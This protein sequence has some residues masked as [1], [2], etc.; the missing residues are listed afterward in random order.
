MFRDRSGNNNT[1]YFVS[2]QNEMT[3]P[4]TSLLPATSNVSEP[5]IPS[6]SANNLLMWLPVSG[7]S[8]VSDGDT[9]SHIPDQSG[10]KFGVYSTGTWVYGLTSASF[11]SQPALKLSSATG[12]WVNIDTDDGE[13]E[14]L[15]TSNGK[16]TTCFMINSP[17]ST[18]DSST[19]TVM[20]GGN[21]GTADTKNICQLFGGRN[22]STFNHR[23]F[24][25]NSNYIRGILTNN[26]K[27]PPQ[28]YS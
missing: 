13:S 21:G 24:F 17:I 16:Y 3:E 11:N 7:L 12:A 22:A 2:T 6:F 9:I 15:T 4:T 27:R 25:N 18:Y 20:F 8:S 26:R 23:Q 5:D 19:V 1:A 28:H 10:N 14:Q